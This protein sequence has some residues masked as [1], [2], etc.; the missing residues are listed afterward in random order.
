[1]HHITVATITHATTSLGAED[2]TGDMCVAALKIDLGCHSDNSEGVTI[3]S[4]VVMA[5]T[6][7]VL[8]PAY[9]L[10]PFDLLSW[11][12]YTTQDDLPRASIRHSELGPSASIINQ[13]KSPTG[14]PQGSLMGAFSQLRFPLPT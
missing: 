1:M 4:E 10:T 5:I 9:Q 6:R 13:D 11:L 8:I 2:S 3:T 14:L 12:F 7:M